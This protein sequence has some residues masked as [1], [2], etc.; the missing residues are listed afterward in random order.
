MTHH[1]SC[2]TLSCPTLS[3]WKTLYKDFRK[4]GR[5]CTKHHQW[6]DC[7]QFLS[8]SFHL[9][10]YQRAH[11]RLL[12]RFPFG[13]LTEEQ[14]SSIWKQGPGEMT[15]DSHSPPRST[16]SGVSLNLNKRFPLEEMYEAGSSY[17]DL[18]GLRRATL[19]VE[20]VPEFIH[21]DN[22]YTISEEP[23][24]GFWL[25]TGTHEKVDKAVERCL[26]QNIPLGEYLLY[27]DLILT[28]EDKRKHRASDGVW[29]NDDVKVSLTQTI[30][31]L[32]GALSGLRETLQGLP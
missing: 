24:R 10:A 27:R 7:T 21:G 16:N 9:R 18:L 13:T 19:Q 25:V 29:R 26:A 2:P 3:L 22:S 20:E 31:S 6:K 23:F 11:M 17:R 14:L 15:W 4:S 5:G 30:K 12:G 28:E 1:K 32:E 8:D